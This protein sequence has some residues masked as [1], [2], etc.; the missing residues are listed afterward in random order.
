MKKRSDNLRNAQKVKNDEFYTRLADIELEL[1]KYDFKDKVIY[2]NCDNPKFSNFIK[3]FKDNFN[4]L[5]IKKLLYSYYDSGNGGYGSFDGIEFKHDKFIFNGDFRCYESIQL[6]EQCD[7][8][9][10]NPPFSLFRDYIK[11]ITKYSK[12]FIIVGGIKFSKHI[13][14]FYKAVL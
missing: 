5:G 13:R 10:S 12:K 9:V 4:K 14:I 2:C 3:Y 7:I 6:L 8:V 1:S 11:Q